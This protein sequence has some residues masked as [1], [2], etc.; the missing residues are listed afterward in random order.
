MQYYCPC[1]EV[2]QVGGGPF[3]LTM[4]GFTNIEEAILEQEHPGIG[5]MLRGILST[6]WGE[7]Q[8]K[9]KDSNEIYVTDTWSGEIAH[10]LLSFSC[11][12]WKTRCQYIHLMKNGTSESEYRKEMEKECEK[13]KKNSLKL[14]KCD[15]HLVNREKSFF[16]QG[17]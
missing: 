1:G 14:M 8:K 17:T 7:I 4:C 5:N 10:T 12:M 3:L 2:W 16:C 11:Q 6:K 9:L 13:M 15:R